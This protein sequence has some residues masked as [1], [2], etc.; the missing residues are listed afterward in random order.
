MKNIVVGVTGG[1]AAYKAAELVSTLSKKGYH[2]H[3]MMTKAGTEFI[4]PLTLQTLSKNSVSVD[5]LEL[6]NGRYVPHIDFANEADLFIII[7]ATAN[8]IAKVAYGLADNLLTTTILATKAPV[9]FVPSMNV[10][11]YENPITQENIEKLKKLGYG[12]VEPETGYLAC[13]VIGKGRLPE[14]SLILDR[15]EHELDKQSANDKDLTGIKVV[16]TAGG[17]REPLDPVRYIGN[18]SS[19]K[20]G[21]ALAQ[22][23][24]ARGA[25]VTLISANTNLDTLVGIKHIKVITAREMQEALLKLYDT[26]DIVIMAAAVADYRPEIVEEQKIKK[27]LEQNEWCLKLIKNPDI[28]SEL[29]KIKKQQ[30]LIGFA[31]ETENLEA[32]ALKKIKSKNLDLIV[33]NNVMEQ[34]IGFESN[35][36]EVTIYFED[37]KNVKIPKM[38]KIELGDHIINE[39]KHIARFKQFKIKGE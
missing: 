24:F 14:I 21:F 22:A 29:G 23:A 39:I 27:S 35:N 36:N 8:T 17:T 20:M 12:F 1:I 4:S 3:V 28:I 6:N 11:M 16:V 26:Q 18:R 38:S 37:G 34:D 30:I 10:N 19:G 25:E 31:A 15:V 2:V 5:H 7:P 32:N 33:A 9:L 13:G